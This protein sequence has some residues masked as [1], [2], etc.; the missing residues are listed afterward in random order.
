MVMVRFPEEGMFEQAFYVVREDV[1]VNKG[2]SGQDVLDEA[3]R[4]AQNHF[5]AKVKK[6]EKFSSFVYF[7]TGAGCVG[8]AWF[9]VMLF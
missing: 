2:V 9:L 4:I 5:P 1:A 8:L 3:C 7:L 6:H